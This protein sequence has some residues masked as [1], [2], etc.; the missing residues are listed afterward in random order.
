MTYLSIIHGANGIVYYT[1]SSSGEGNNL[2][3]HDN[4][5]V[6]DNLKKVVGELAYL[7]DVLAERNTTEKCTSF[8]IKGAEK[9]GLG[10]PALNTLLK[11]Y[12]GNHYLFAANS[13]QQ[14]IRCQFKP[15]IGNISEVSAMFEDRTLP[16]KDGVFVDDFRAYDVHVYQW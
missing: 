4:K 8:I 1:Y 3:A 11:V 16:V 9:D 2:G 10:Y 12:Q 13:A 15:A 14:P 7:H 6:W 5:F